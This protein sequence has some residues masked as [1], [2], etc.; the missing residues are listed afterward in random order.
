VAAVP[1]TALPPK[2]AYSYR[3]DSLEQ[4]LQMEYEDSSCSLPPANGGAV[5]RVPVAR[6]RGRGAAATRAAL[7]DMHYASSSDVPLTPDAPKPPPSLTKPTAFAETSLQEKSIRKLYYDDERIYD[8]PEGVEEEFDS[9]DDALV[10]SI[11]VNH[12][13]PSSQYAPPI[14]PHHWMNHRRPPQHHGLRH[15]RLPG[16]GCEDSHLQRRFG[17]PIAPCRQIGQQLLVNMSSTE[18]ES[19]LSARS[20]PTPVGHMDSLILHHGRA[21]FEMH[22]SGLISPPEESE[23]TPVLDSESLPAPPEFSGA[24]V[25]VVSDAAATIGDGTTDDKDLED[26]NTNN[27]ALGI[28]Q[29]TDIEGE[30][31]LSIS[32]K[33]GP[34]ADVQLCA[35]GEGQ[36]PSPSPTKKVL[37][38]KEDEVSPDADLM[39]E[40]TTS[41]E[42]TV[43]RRAPD[44][45]A[46][47][48]TTTTNELDA[49]AYER[50]NRAT[51]DEVETDDGLLLDEVLTM[52]SPPT[53]YGDDES[54][55]TNNDVKIAE[56][57]VRFGHA[58]ST[59]GE[60]E[61]SSVPYI[62]DSERVDCPGCL[63]RDEANKQLALASQHSSA[64]S[65]VLV[66]KHRLSIEDRETSEGSSFDLAFIPPPPPIVIESDENEQELEPIPESS[67]EPSPPANEQQVAKIPFPSRTLSRISEGGSFSDTNCPEET[68]DD[69]VMVDD[70]PTEEEDNTFSEPNITTSEDNENPPSLNSD[71]PENSGGAVITVRSC[72]GGGMPSVAQIVHECGLELG[73]E[74]E[75]PSPPSSTAG[76]AGAADADDRTE[77]THVENSCI[78]PPEFMSTDDQEFAHDA[79]KPQEKLGGEEAAPHVPDEK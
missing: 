32:R 57:Y 16:G 34:G 47:T 21:E 58:S 64:D 42:S 56:M 6:G 68:G 28:G 49:D 19:A 61:A 35:A 18:S 8:V 4:S 75:F 31:D 25:L 26:D 7:D 3:D 24:G 14:P 38:F 69:D 43:R 22:A 29:D 62:D 54:D 73:A 59:N 70:R 1:V 65:D 67:E 50:R 15:H 51:E 5:R 77:V 9:V 10:P 79:Q 20:A 37:T 63:K 41:Q 13:S 11:A 78:S 48:T 55:T 45:L 33:S 66:E 72:R 46:T 60:S 2:N 40:M 27:G 52:E 12:F 53:V 17:P 71:L 23:D 76:A 36:H 30:D 39:E 74:I 44:S